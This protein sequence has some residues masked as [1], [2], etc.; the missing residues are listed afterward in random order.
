[1]TTTSDRRYHLVTFGCKLNQHDSA[2]IE[3]LLQR[4]GY[5]A[6]SEP[7]DA[8]L[9]VVNS[10]TVTLEADHDARKAAR[11]LR[12]SNPT[13][14]M[15]ATGCYAERDPAA[16]RALALFDDVVGHRERE[17]LPAALLGDDHCSSVPLSL[18]FPDPAR[19]FLK[20][21]EGCDLACSYCIIPTVRGRSRSLPIDLI[22]GQLRQLVAQ[23]VREVG[24]TG[25]NIGM[26][27]LDLTP[28]QRLVDLVRA[29]LTAELP[30][31]VRL[32]SLEPRTVEDELLR[33]IAGAG[34]RVAAH[35]Q[36]PL[37]SG[38]DR[39]LARMHRNY[40]TAFYRQ[41]IERAKSLV[42]RICLGADLIVG[43]PG[44]STADHESSCRFVADL[45]LDYL[46]VFSYS[47]RPGTPAALLGS[48]IDGPTKRAR[49]REAIAIGQGHARRFRCDQ[50]GSVQTGLVLAHRHRSGQAR[51]LTGN[52][53]EV[54]LAEATPG[55]WTTVRLCRLGEADLA[56]WAEVAA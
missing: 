18:S 36:V 10:C 23:G 13:A 14:R 54:L 33:T 35:L 1:M 40:R 42:P 31:R 38:C 19:A 12:R 11:R 44:E 15:I 7:S 20:V 45:P 5:T 26:W 28:R 41:R 43:F 49:A 32:G 22:V 24:F 30:L 17:R 37:Q 8:Q 2:V 55:S 39:T 47:P 3:G 52:Y 16:L 4:G 53:I 6:V 50:L 25:V 56:V 46:H 21:Q 27:G 34:D 9:I 48:P 51:V 29:I